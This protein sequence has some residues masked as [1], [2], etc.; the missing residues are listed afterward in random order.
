MERMGKEGE[1]GV[2]FTWQ[3]ERL[4]VSPGE[5]PGHGGGGQPH[6]LT[7]QHHVAVGVVTHVLRPRHDR[8]TCRTSQNSLSVT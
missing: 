3:V 5:D 2:Q 6:S 1:R 4:V 7:L 8:R